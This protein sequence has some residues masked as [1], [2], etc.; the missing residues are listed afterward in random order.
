MGTTEYYRD[1]GRT[2]GV[3][4]IEPLLGFRLF[5]SKTSH[6][7]RY[8]RA[9]VALAAG[10][11]IR[12]VIGGRD[13]N[14]D[15]SVTDWGLVRFGGP[16]TSALPFERAFAWRPLPARYA[17]NSTLYA[18]VVWLALGG[19][20]TLWRLAFKRRPLHECRFCG[21]DLR[22]LALGICPECGRPFQTRP[23]PGAA[24]DISEAGETPTPASDERTH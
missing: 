3:F 21:Y 24:Q 22:G 11:P 18:L 8:A 9:V 19:Y 15:E 17:I 23:A 20:A 1:V 5:S 13:L 10:W 7:D 2:E 14:D 4:E 6:V 16:K 12:C